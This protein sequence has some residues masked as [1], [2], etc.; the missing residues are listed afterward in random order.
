MLRWKKAKTIAFAKK[1]TAENAFGKT[2]QT[3][4]IEVLPQSK[5]LEFKS[6]HQKI[7]F[8]NTTQLV[9][10]VDNV[11][12]VELNIGG[13]IELLT[14][15]GEKNINPTEHTNYILITTALDSITKTEKEVTVQVFKKIEIIS[16]QSDFQFVVQSIPITLTWQVENANKII[17]EDDIGKQID[18]TN[19]SKFVEQIKKD[20]SYRIRCT[21]DLFDAVSDKIAIHV[22]QN[23]YGHS[24][25]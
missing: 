17:L 23:K 11:E 13:R 15:K 16:F 1:L 10:N 5:I 12:K 2:E 8:G 24:S 25:L 4:E 7:G 3:I 21:N 9:W 19:N 22:V 20:S 14:N 18:V 6:K